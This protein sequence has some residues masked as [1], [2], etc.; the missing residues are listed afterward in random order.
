MSALQSLLPVVRD[1]FCFECGEALIDE[2][3]N[4]SISKERG[5]TENI[6]LKLLPFQGRIT[7]LHF[8]MN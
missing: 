2:P 1:A 3:S 8:W 4:R 5:W 7:R 6:L